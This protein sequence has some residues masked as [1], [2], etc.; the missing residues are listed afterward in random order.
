MILNEAAEMYFD[1]KQGLMKPS[2]FANLQRMY[3][4]HIREYIG[5]MEIDDLNNRQMQKFYNSLVRRKC[6]NNSSKTLSKGAAK[7]IIGLLK[8][9]CYFAM[10]EGEMQEHRYKLK[11]P[12]GFREIDEDRPGYLPEDTYGLVLDLCLEISSSSKYNQAKIFTII[13]LTTGMR[14]GEVC[15]LQWKDFDF[16]SST[17][18]VN[19]TVQRIVNEDGSSYIHIGE[20]KSKTSKRACVLL[21]ITKVALNKYKSTLNDENPDY[22]MLTNKDKPTEPRT[23][24]Q[25]YQRFLKSNN[26]PYIHPH[27]LRHSFCTYS[28]S[29]GGD[30]KTT[31]KLMGHANTGITLDTYTHI[32]QKQVET[33]VNNLNKIFSGSNNKVNEVN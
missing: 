27:A 2:S 32:T 17:V 10:E 21:D 13:A 3:R 16:K 8:T 23:V 30:V 12:Y 31:S 18:K 22:F 14:I 20:P 9:I 7:D 29:N 1:L 19:K 25:T 26:I 6:L 28:I 15:G 33:T 4:D 5:Y 11:T 24:R